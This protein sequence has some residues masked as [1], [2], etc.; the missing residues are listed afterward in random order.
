[1]ALVAGPEAPR[2]AAVDRQVEQ[3][4]TCIRT[5]A[6]GSG[7]R[8]QPA[9]ID[10]ILLRH[11]VDDG[12][13]AGKPRGS[14]TQ[15]RDSPRAFAVGI[16][17][18]ILMLGI[19]GCGRSQEAEIRDAIKVKFPDG[20][21]RCLGLSTDSIGIHVVQRLGETL[22]YPGA[23]PTSPVRHAFVFYAIPA[24]APVP[25]LVAD[26]TARGILKR[27]EVQAT[28]DTETSGL[29]PQI[30]SAD[31]IYSHQQWVRHKSNSFPVSIYE[32]HPADDAFDYQVQ[33]SARLSILSSASFPSR[34]YDDPFPSADQHYAIPTI[35]PYALSIVT[36]ACFEETVDQVANIRQSQ[37]FGGGQLVEA[38]VTFD[39]A[40][41][42]WMLTPAF[43]RAAIGNDTASI[44]KPRHATVVLQVMDGR[45]SYLQEHSS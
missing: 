44:T 12:A 25:E 28:V 45:L 35:D 7:S 33:A 2:R 24:S 29:G 10:P 40:P 39:Q 26:L 41:P 5:D 8:S 38:D 43:S 17:S 9:N 32:T 30:V 1:M 23:G 4:R 34:I 22:Y 31:G 3:S 37:A 42:S 20:K 15:G 16:A 11:T 19:G 36:A 27:E 6:A 13:V 21:R 14:H 18:M